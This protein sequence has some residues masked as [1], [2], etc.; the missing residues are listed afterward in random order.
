MN[1]QILSKKRTALVVLM[2]GLLCGGN[3]VAG[4]Q[5]N[6]AEASSARHFSCTNATLAG[7]FAVINTIGFVPGG[8]PPAPLV[9]NA[10]VGVMTLDGAGHVSFRSY[11]QS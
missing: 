7:R 1:S 9:P 10:L 2:C 11:D 8:P 6:A 4:E 3:A 5:Q